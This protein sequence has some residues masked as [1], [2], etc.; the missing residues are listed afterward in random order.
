MAAEVRTLGQSHIKVSRKLPSKEI[1]NLY[2]RYGWF[3]V[4]ALRNV[5]TSHAGIDWTVL[6]ERCTKPEMMAV[7]CA[8]LPVPRGGVSLSPKILAGLPAVADV[9]L[10]Q[11]PDA[12]K[13]QPDILSRRALVVD[14]SDG[15]MAS[16]PTWLARFTQLA[17]GLVRA[18]QDLVSPNAVAGWRPSFAASAARQRWFACRKSGRPRSCYDALSPSQGV[19]NCSAPFAPGTQ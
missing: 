15:G 7:S 14:F 4:C 8:R 19:A 16:S 6:G 5:S 2:H 9:G 3:S 13:D 11:Q 17:R 10:V 18:R 12:S 1:A